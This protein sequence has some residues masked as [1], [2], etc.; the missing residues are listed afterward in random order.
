MIAIRN[1]CLA[2]LATAF[3]MQAAVAQYR[4]AA[5]NSRTGTWE[6]YGGLRTQFGETLDFNGGSSIKTDNALGLGFG[7]GYNLDNH[8]LFGGDLSFASVDYD[9]TVASADTPGVFRPLSGKFDTFGMSASATW[10]FLEGPLTP[11]VSGTIGYTWIDTNIAQG[12]PEVG[13]WWDPWYGQICTT[14]QDTKTEN[15]FSYGLGLG[16]RWEF[17]P[18]WFGRISYEE[19]WIGIDN[20][21]G[22]PSF[23]GLHLDIGSRF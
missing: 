10:H 14:F 2:L 16:M 13:C 23:G 4:S 22:T 9:G 8:L 21:N 1:L 18:G 12:P 7:F 17:T 20:A 19:R 3:G 5:S 15:S 6:A 11:F